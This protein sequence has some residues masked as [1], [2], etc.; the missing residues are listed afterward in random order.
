MFAVVF[1]ALLLEVA[2]GE[3][4]DPYRLLLVVAF[5]AQVSAVV[6]LHRRS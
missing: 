6:V 5:G 3:D 2:S 4:G 1:G